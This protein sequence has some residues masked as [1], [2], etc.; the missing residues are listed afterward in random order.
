MAGAQALV[1]LL[2]PRLGPARA[3]ETRVGRW[4]SRAKAL[5]GLAAVAVLAAL[6]PAIQTLPT[7]EWMPQ[8]KR[9]LVGISDVMPGFYILILVYRHLAASPLNAIGAYIPNGAMYAGLLALLVLPAA[10]IHPR[11]R[12][13]WLHVAVVLTALAVHVWLG[14]AGLAPP[15]LARPDRLPE[16]PDH[17]AGRLQPG[18]A[19][20]VRGGGPDRAGAAGA[21]LADRGCWGWR[22]WHW[23]GC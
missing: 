4:R 22:P 21:A 13:V 9:E 19:G 6:L 17:P 20:R 2:W 10:L 8:L 16:D 15:P 14:A 18:D 1:C 3:L 5:G 11:R 23:V 7:V 12:D